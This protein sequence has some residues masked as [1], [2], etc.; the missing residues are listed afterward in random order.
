MLDREVVAHPDH[1]YD[2]ERS[3]VVVS[4]IVEP[5]VLHSG[6]ERLVALVKES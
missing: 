4:L 1:F 6:I 3:S 2:L 5:Q